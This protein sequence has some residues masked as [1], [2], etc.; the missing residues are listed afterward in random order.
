MLLI[1]LQ[2][3]DVAIAQLK[4]TDAKRVSVNTVPRTVFE[5]DSYVLAPNLIGPET[6]LHCKWQRS[7]KVV[8]YDQSEYTLLNLITK[9][10]REVHASKLKSFRFH[11]TQRAPTDTAH[12]DCME[13]FLVRKSFY[14]LKIKNLLLEWNSI[15]NGWSTIEAI[16]HGN[17]GSPCALQIN[18]ISICTKTTCSMFF[19]DNFVLYLPQW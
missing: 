11:P 6:R 1:Q 4:S 7:F 8:S 17:L 12:C 18:F 15:L 19:Q 10:T 13:F 16:I 5:I 3:N 9:K 14:M 2:L